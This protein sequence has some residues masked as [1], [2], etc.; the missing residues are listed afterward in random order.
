MNAPP[1]SGPQH[2][3][4]RLI[5]LPPQTLTSTSLRSIC[6]GMR[7]QFTHFTHPISRCLL[8]ALCASAVNYAFSRTHHECVRRVRS[9]GICPRR[10]FRRPNQIFKTS[11]GFR[12]QTR[13]FHQVARHII[14][15]PRHRDQ[16][17]DGLVHLPT[18][19]RP[20]FTTQHWRD[21]ATPPTFRLSPNPRGSAP[22]L[23][24]DKGL[25][26]F[27]LVTNLS[28]VVR[29]NSP[30]CS[31]DVPTLPFAAPWPP[32]AAGANH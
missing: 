29:Q 8:R 28:D 1:L 4:S 18:Q 6:P 14:F 32:P 15:R 31:G 2:R 7:A 5:S 24:N 19:F 22:Y 20:R 23:G 17:H 11:V 10:V 3:R 12:Q 16:A 30:N 13:H 9:S 26:F 25:R 27:C 21:F